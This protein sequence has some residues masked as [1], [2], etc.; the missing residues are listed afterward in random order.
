MTP[1]FDQR[2]CLPSVTIF[3][4]TGPKSFISTSSTL[5]RPFPTSKTQGL[6][7]RTTGSVGSFG[8]FFSDSGHHFSRSRF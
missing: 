4:E 2:F 7:T 1:D 8:A 3:G 6:A 5:R